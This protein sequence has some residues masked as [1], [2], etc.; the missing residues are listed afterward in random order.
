MILEHLG[1]RQVYY[2]NRLEMIFCG[3]HYI[4]VGE[5]IAIWSPL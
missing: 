5:T 2:K 3:E 4:D 1:T